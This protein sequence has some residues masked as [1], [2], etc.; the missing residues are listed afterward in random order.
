MLFEHRILFTWMP[1]C[2]L[3][4]IFLVCRFLIFNCDLKN[5]I[6]VFWFSK[7]TGELLI[8]SKFFGDPVSCWVSIF[9]SE[10]SNE[11]F[12]FIQK[13][14]RKKGRSSGARGWSWTGSKDCIC[15]S[16]IF[17]HAPLD[18]SC[19][20]CMQYFVSVI[21]LGLFTNAAGNNF[22]RYA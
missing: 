14:Q 5:A 20:I 7:M 8:L 16:G 3:Y 1:F 22:H 2:I 21:F 18:I 9:G 6:R 4:F 11:N 12:F 10:N 19:L 17:V 15:L 13:I